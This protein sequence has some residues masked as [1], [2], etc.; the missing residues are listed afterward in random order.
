[1]YNIHEV[2]VKVFPLYNTDPISQYQNTM[3]SKEL[4]QLTMLNDFFISRPII[5]VPVDAGDDEVV[6]TVPAKTVGTDVRAGLWTGIAMDIDVT[7]VT[8][9]GMVVVLIADTITGFVPG[10]D[11][12]VLAGVDAKTDLKFIDTRV[13]LEDSLGF[14]C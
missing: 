13:S 1:M 12:D 14:C 10:I 3:T 7:I 6:V 11:V 4:I 2:I 5:D 8:R 9:V